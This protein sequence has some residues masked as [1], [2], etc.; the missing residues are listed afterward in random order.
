MRDWSGQAMKAEEMR[1]VKL[2][3]TQKTCEDILFL[4]ESSVLGKHMIALCKELT[5]ET[6]LL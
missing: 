3:C 5:N 4:I 1:S 6:S 2:S